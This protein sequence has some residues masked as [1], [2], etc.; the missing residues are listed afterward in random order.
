MQ[1]DPMKTQ[2]EVGD[3]NNEKRNKR[4]TKSKFLLIAGS[5]CLIYLLIMCIYS[6]TM[7]KACESNMEEV[8]VD[9][10][11][12][13]EDLREKFTIEIS[14]A[15]MYFIDAI[16]YF[17]LE[18]YEKSA[19][20][21]HKAAKLEHKGAYYLLSILYTE[22]LGVEKDAVKGALYLNQAGDEGRRLTE[23]QI[24][25]ASNLGKEISKATETI[26]KF[27]KENSEEIE[28]AITIIE[29]NA[30]QIESVDD[31]LSVLEDEDEEKVEE[32]MES[33]EDAAEDLGL[34]IDLGKLKFSF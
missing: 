19:E 26:E 17:L 16:A 27:A 4:T 21:G 2:Q 3:N 13:G 9:F 6:F 5:G 29:Q 8:S 33:V 25:K 7:F 32:L 31:A 22:G 30:E 20:Y 11:G 1:L 24:N 12:V 23:E 28:N 15:D 14:E 10:S 18:D 34:D